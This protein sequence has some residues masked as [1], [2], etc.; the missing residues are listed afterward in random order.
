M[1]VLVVGAAGQLGRA[2]SSYLADQHLV[3]QW[4]FPGYDIADP[5]IADAV[6]TLAPDLVI[7]AAAWTDVDGAES[8]V[9]A[10]YAA[11][12][13][14]PKYLAEGCARCGAALLHVSTNE[15]FAGEPGRFYREYDS[16][17]PTGIYARSKAAGEQA[18]RQILDRLYIVRVAWLY[19]P[20]GNNFPAKIVRAA[21]KHGALRVVS[22]E[23]GN[24]TYAPD[25]AEAIAY[26]IQSGRYGIYHL[27]NE[28]HTS[29][30]EWAN[31]L[32]EF[33]GRGHVPVTPIAAHEW[34]RPAPPPSHAVLVNQAAAAL[35]I[36]LR[37]WQ[38]ALVDY[39]R[40]EPE[41]IQLGNGD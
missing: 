38:E 4:T 29:R 36:R 2:V 20:G 31:T 32:L 5:Q 40:S 1:H 7:N 8:A 16:P 28:G 22:D 33:S 10:A 14:G 26:L 39:L 41:L 30:F 23:F 37:P 24:P 34:P 17:Q 27:V 11:N 3:S 15:V 25:V 12:A 21:D 18:A 13:L 6:V 19:A 9:D 35:G